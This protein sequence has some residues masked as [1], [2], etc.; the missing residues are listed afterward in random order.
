MNKIEGSRCDL[1]QDMKIQ[2]IAMMLAVSVLGAGCAKNELETLPTPSISPSMAQTAPSVAASTSSTVSVSTHATNT[3]T[4]P[5]SDALSRVTKKSFGLYV[6]PQHSPVSPERFKG[7]HVGTDFETTAD[8][9]DAVVSVQAICDGA[10]AMKKRAT[11]YGGVAVQR[12]K[13]NG[14]EVTVIYG[15]LKLTSVTASVGHVFRAGDA[16]GVLGKGFSTETD[17]ER[18]HLHLGIHRGKAISILG[19]VQSKAALSAWIDPM[20]V[21]R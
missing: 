12:C 2:F 20:S 3:I 10:L 19:Y 15:H 9:K 14:G 1:D 17:G 13:I 8:E 18:K 16:L 7:Y 6:T 21:L 4:L 11:G 5:L